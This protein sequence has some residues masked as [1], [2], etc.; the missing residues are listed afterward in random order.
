MRSA[1]TSHMDLDT[2]SAD[3]TY[4]L[5][6]EPLASFTSFDKKP[7]GSKGSKPK[8]ITDFVASVDGLTTG[9]LGRDCT[10]TPPPTKP[11]RKDQI[12]SVELLTNGTNDLGIEI[13]A[14]PIS[15]TRERSGS[16]GGA[17]NC[18][19]SRSNLVS[20]QSGSQGLGF[21]SPVLSGCAM[22]VV[23]V[24][25]QSVAHKDGRIKVN[26]EVIDL[27]GKSLLRETKESVR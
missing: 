14:V 21:G 11:P 20:P 12:F 9:T 4:F 1:S 10:R 19:G 5:A 26:D 27:N 16:E 24:R 22:R 8:S 13:D 3:D 15:V 2:S 17:G 23:V 7:S 6:Q 25:G 18:W